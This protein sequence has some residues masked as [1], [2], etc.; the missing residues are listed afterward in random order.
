MHDS[1]VPEIK[2]RLNIV[3]VVGSYVRLTKSGVHWKACCPF[4]NE[5]T[6]SFM[7]NEERQMF[8]CF[9]CAKGG[10][11][12]SFIEEIEGIG[13]REALELLAERAGVEIPAY[14]ARAA[15]F[16]DGMERPDRGREILELATKFMEKQ[17]WDGEGAK[18]ALP[19]L[20]QRGISDESLRMFRVGYSPSGWRH[21]YDFLLSR[22]YVP[23]E[24]ESV[25]LAI[26]KEGRSGHYDRFRDR[27]M[28]PIMDVVGR[29]IGYSARMMPGGDER[30]AKYINTPETALYH[31]SRAIYGISQAKQAIKEAGTSILVEGQMDVI[32]CH[33][34]GF[35]NTVAASGT[36]LTSEHLDMLK[37]YGNALKLFFDMDGAGQEASRKATVIALGKEMSVSIVSLPE[38]KDAADAALGNPSVLR[39]AVAEAVPAPEYFMRR[40]LDGFDIAVPEGKRAAAAAYAPILAAMSSDIDRNFWRGELASR[41]RVD[42]RAL[43]GVLRQADMASGNDLSVRTANDAALTQA[44]GP[45]PF[46]RRSDTILDGIIG[47]LL[48]DPTLVDGMIVTDPVAQRLSADGIYVALRE[49]DVGSVMDRLTDETVKSRA[50]R[51]LFEADRFATD[52]KGY[53]FEVR[54]RRAELL[55]ELIGRLMTEL[56]KEEIAA[57]AAEISEAQRAGDRERQQ[58][59]LARHR[60]LMSEN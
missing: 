36:A 37:R 23:D 35:R 34:A 27:I 58:V 44:V 7:V 8:H 22:G 55:K 54:E 52:E 4:H 9:G 30:Q 45:S 38:G 46:S 14:R 43:F 40:F 21:L 48:S 50:A 33:Q 15:S 16:V 26:A 28:F 19:Y 49:G 29:V 2:S 10:D 57:L 39:H 47:L 24:L 13:F 20:R 53:D 5:K 42:E 12:F 3:D 18:S 56:R 31:K 6:P 59:L 51:L 1:I 25:G 17:L 32:A 41:L 11:M 60:T